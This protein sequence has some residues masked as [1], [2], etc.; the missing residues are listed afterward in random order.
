MGVLVQAFC[1]GSPPPHN[2]RR[3]ALITAFPAGED[4]GGEGRAWLQVSTH[5][6]LDSRQPGAQHNAQGRAGDSRP[7]SQVPGMA[8]SAQPQLT[9]PGALPLSSNA[10]LSSNHLTAEPNPKQL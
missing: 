2:S 3:W 7:H 8:A 10:C 1:W 4:W 9:Q 5:T 6:A